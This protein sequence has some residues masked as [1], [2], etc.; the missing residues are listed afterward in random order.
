MAI[1]YASNA[2]IEKIRTIGAIPSNSSNF[3]D[4]KLAILA[5]DEMQSTVVPLIMMAK[6]EY[7]VTYEDFDITS[8]S[9]PTII[10]IPSGAIFDKIADLTIAQTNNNIT[11]ELSVPEISRETLTAGP[12]LT[13]IYYQNVF[14][15]RIQDSNIIFYPGTYVNLPQTFLRL[16]FYRRPLELVTTS[17]AGKIT[18]INGNIL[19]LSQSPASWA[20]GNELQAVSQLPPFRNTGSFTITAISNPT[21]TI[22]DSTGLS[23]GD[24][25]ALDGYCPIPQIPVE[26]MSFLI[27]CVV[28][29]VHEAM[30]DEKMTE[31]AVLKKK[32]LGAML[33]NS[34]SP[35][36]DGERQVIQNRYSLGRRM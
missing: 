30:A 17:N 8:T 36:V 26:A 10:P 19:T 21:I 34:I 9:E 4:A 3:T 23:V 2:L 18:N 33:V 22:D 29:R 15:F 16:Y 5:N 14:G 24:W 20:I 32:E 7:Y 35:R 28:L 12:I 13:T 27:S 1:N 25:V 11:T 6:Q 31:L